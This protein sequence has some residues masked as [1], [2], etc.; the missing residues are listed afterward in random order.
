MEFE[1]DPA[2]AR[3]NLLK[4]KLSFDDAARALADPD[5]LES[6]DD[7]SDYGEDRVQTIC[8][9]DTDFLFV[10]SVVRRPD[11]TRIISARRATRYEETL[12]Y[13]RGW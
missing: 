12:Y 1:W 13:R 5:R 9:L 8:R 4:H 3:Q 6:I 10:V 2:K 7:R 11:L